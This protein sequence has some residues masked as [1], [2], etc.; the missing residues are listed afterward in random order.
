[1]E[2]VGTQERYITLM[3][4]AK[5]RILAAEKISTS[6]TPINSLASIDY[7]L[8][9][10]QIRKVIEI[11]TFTS[12]LREQDRYKKRREQDRQKN[13]SDH[14][15]ATKDWNAPQMLE[16]LCSLSPYALPIPLK[17]K[18]KLKN[19]ITHFDN[20]KITVNQERLIDIYKKAGGYIH[21]GN[22]LPEDFMAYISKN[23][24]KYEGAKKEAIRFL[25]FLRDLLW[26]HVSVQIEWNDPND[27]KEAGTPTSAWIVNF[28]ESDDHYISITIG[29][30]T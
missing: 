29:E 9:F 3:G 15:N 26:S 18:A 13:T 16:T 7:E 19:G 2:S 10:L 14:G 25:K 12:V 24:K 20:K 27:P 21:V 6:D 11:V 28:G 30:G 5:L 22:P 1:M 8:C 17:K 23:R 4:E